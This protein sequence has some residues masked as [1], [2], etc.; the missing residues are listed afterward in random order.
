[1][2]DQEQRIDPYKYRTGKE[3]F[4]LWFSILATVGYYIWIA[5]SV[6]SEDYGSLKNPL[7]LLAFVLLFL[8]LHLLGMAAIRINSVKIGPNQF[9]E[10]WNSAEKLSKRLG[11]NKLPD[12]YILNS[13]G[14]LN[15][16]AARLVSRKILVIYSEL[17][18]ALIE[19]KDHQQL[20]AV[21]GHELGHHALNHTHFYNWFLTP[22][23][24]IPFFGAA[25]SRSREYSADR[26]M[27]G[28]I[29]NQEVCERALVKL[30]VGKKLGNLVNIDEYTSQIKTETGFFVWLSEKMAS[31]PHL[32]KRIIAIKKIN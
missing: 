27:K 14:Q 5:N 32:P 19:D 8:F 23:E 12:I 30:A 16:F 15:A 1:M 29:Q 10:I 9:P 2:N 31:H 4:Y 21:I 3:K 22:A 7:F 6:L 20:E 26:I 28:L 11:L 25:F 18:E 24:M 13:G 17:A